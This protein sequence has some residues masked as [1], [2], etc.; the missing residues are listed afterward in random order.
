M[1]GYMA[2]IAGDLEAGL[3]AVV[4]TNGM[5]GVSAAA[6]AAVRI[7]R[8]LEVPPPKP[9]N[10]TEKSADYAGVYRCGEKTLTLTAEGE[11]LTLQHGAEQ[12]ALERA[13][14]EDQFHVRHSDFA[15]YLLRFG[16]ENGK[17]VEAFHG[18]DWYVGAGY[19]GPTA[20]DLPAEWQTYPGH[21]RSYNPWYS[22]FRVVARKG[23]LALIF[24]GGE[25][26]ALKP[27]TG[28]AFRVGEDERLPERVRFGA[29]LN[30]VAEQATL[31]GG[32]Y[33]RTFTP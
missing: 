15:L 11:R 21:Y 22:N 25:E 9:V 23:G 29:V 10:Q 1:V 7:L 4:L 16:R 20:F 33:S 18:P 32:V 14:G 17:V 28:G 30:R 24:P 13:S 26:Q 3:G 5:R 6:R 2:A 27:V 19:A 31:A 12:V 8:G